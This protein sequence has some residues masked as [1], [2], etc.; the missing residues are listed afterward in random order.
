VRNPA[1]INPIEH[2]SEANMM[3]MNTDE[4]IYDA[5]FDRNNI[6]QVDISPALVK[7][8]MVPPISFSAS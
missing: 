4:I 1:A 6:Q 5:N 8:S 7:I 2:N 3:Q